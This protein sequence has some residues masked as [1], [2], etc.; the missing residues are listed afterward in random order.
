MKNYKFIIHPATLLILASFFAVAFIYIANNKG[1][2][3]PEQWLSI[4]PIQ[5]LGNAWEFNWLKSNPGRYAEYPHGIGAE[6]SEA[7]KTIIAQFYKSKNID[8]LDI[9]TE[10]N[11]NLTT[12]TACSCPIGYTLNVKVNLDDA[13]LMK[14]W[15]W[16]VNSE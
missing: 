6:L 15:G 11:P 7:E 8:I 5:C 16:R 12:C 10:D 14:E 1:Q 4:S 2:T 3:I 13:K 9:A